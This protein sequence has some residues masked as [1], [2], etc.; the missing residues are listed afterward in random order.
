MKNNKNKIIQLSTLLQKYYFSKNILAIQR[1]FKKNQINIINQAMEHID[2]ID[3]VIFILITL[4]STKNNNNMFR[5]FSDNLQRL[6]IEQSTNEQLKIIFKHLY[7]DEILDIA[8]KNNDLFKKILL[9]ISSKQRTLIKQISNFDNDVAGSIMN[10]DYIAFNEN[11]TIKEC[12][13][14]YKKS[15]DQIEKNLSFFIVSSDMKLVGHVQLQTLFFADDYSLTVDKIMDQNIIYVHANDDIEN[16]IN[17][18]QD[19]NLES[20]PVL[21]ENDVLVGVINDND[22]LPAIDEETTED[23]YHMYG[24]QK[25]EKSYLKSNLWSVVKSRLLWVSILMISATLTSIVIN[26]FE[27]WGIN[28]TLGLSTILLIPIIPVITGTSGNTG[29]QASATIIRALAVGEVTPKE[30]KKVILKEFNTGV[31]LGALLAVF[32]IIRLAIYFAVPEFRDISHTDAIGHLTIT[33]NYAIA[34]LAS[35][36]SSIALWIAVILSKLLGSILP[37]IATK[38][39]FDP[40]V[41]SS[42]LIATTIDVCSTSILFAI[43]IGLLTLIIN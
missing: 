6:I 10:P 35:L 24:I 30:Y 36:A 21:N 5:Y 34:M 31:V 33:N 9:S 12:I 11:Y 32:N 18:I 16:I 40:T 41:M 1:L 19:Y 29:S 43:G 7:P 2:N 37:L 38:L 15:Y 3:I 17:I 14:L 25:L 4:S 23:I 8:N 20:V 22:I 13:D 42:P 39:K 27:N 26:R 28:V